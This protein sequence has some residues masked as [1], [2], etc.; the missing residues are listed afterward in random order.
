[1]TDGSAHR[2]HRIAFLSSGAPEADRLRDQL[3]ARYGNSPE[4]E[5]DVVVRVG[6]DPERGVSTMRMLGI[7][8]ALAGLVIAML[9]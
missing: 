8:L 2:Y 5:A 4:N 3:A 7:G 6:K 9:G 1:M